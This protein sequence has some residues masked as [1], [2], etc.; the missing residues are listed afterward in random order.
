MT[1]NVWKGLV[2]VEGAMGGG[3]KIFCTGGSTWK[4][5]V[6]STIVCC[7]EETERLPIDSTRGEERVL[8]QSLLCLKGNTEGGMGCVSSFG[9]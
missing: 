9:W 3:T 7:V 6:F 4:E 1:L 8:V 2:A 5:W